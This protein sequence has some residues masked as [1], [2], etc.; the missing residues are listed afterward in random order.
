MIDVSIFQE[1]DQTTLI[2]NRAWKKDRITLTASAL[3]DDNGD[4]HTTSTAKMI[5]ELAY[6]KKQHLEKDF[7]G[8]YEA[9]DILEEIKLL[10]EQMLGEIKTEMEITR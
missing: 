6:R 2:M 8:S 4:V 5:M 10:V 9:R 1:G 3:T 7:Y